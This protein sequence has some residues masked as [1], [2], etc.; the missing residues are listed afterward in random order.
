MTASSSGPS[1]D[2]RARISL[3][4]LTVRAGQV[5]SGRVAIAIGWTTF[6]MIM[7]QT[8]RLIGSLIMTRLLVPEMFG[9]MSIVLSVQITLSLLLDIGLRAA[10]IQSPRGNDPELLNT[11]WTIQIIRGTVI[12]ILIV[13]L[14]MSLPNAMQ[15]GL[16]STG[17]A[18]ATPE[19]PLILAVA[20]VAAI[21]NGFESTNTI[22]AE[23]NLAR[24]RFTY[25]QL[26]GQ[27]VGFLTMVGLGLLTR[28]IW[29]LVFSGLISTLLVSSFSHVVLPG[30]RNKLAWNK[31][32]RAELAKYGS[33]ILLSSA[34]SVLANQADRLV[35]AGLVDSATL[36]FYAI[37]LNL[38]MIVETLASTCIWSVFL[39]A[40]SEAK[41]DRSESFRHKYFR[42]R[43]PLDL[44]I[45]ATA[46]GL[47]ATGPLIIEILYDDR[48]LP[49]GE[50]LKILSFLLIF[51]RYSLT[52][53]AYMAL[54][55]PH[56]TA[57]ISLVK[58]ASLIPLLFILY[59]YFGFEG[60]IF[61]VSFHMLPAILVMFW[62]NRKND[63]NDFRFE[64]AVLPA[65]PVGY[66]LGL[67]FIHFIEL[68]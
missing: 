12:C 7:S 14:A 8:I 60:A 59:R 19:L 45:L 46:G 26:T 34:A 41:R 54:G 4:S 27:I 62:F 47:F 68:F 15:A 64:L 29:A 11:A 50:M 3:A 44:L 48:Y 22:T 10:I 1:D 40:L 49:A 56:L 35:L 63:L 17:S 36:G 58:C 28:S 13:L 66:G 38:A 20:S 37:A 32:A 18:W 57:I 2:Q 39:P 43:V 6:A 5:L 9:T 24:K 65:W 55:K 67:A 52:S 21:I 42:L 23:R 16:L 53:A 33:W 51:A 31:D 61:A 25:L 30:I